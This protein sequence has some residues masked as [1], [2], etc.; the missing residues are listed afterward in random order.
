MRV[1]QR[2]TWPALGFGVTDLA[3]EELLREF[4][5]VEGIGNFPAAL[6][7]ALHPRP[8]VVALFFAEVLQNAQKIN[9]F[10]PFP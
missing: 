7:E 4:R 9:L 10:P 1:V 2:K 5:V 8:D 6:V 3:L